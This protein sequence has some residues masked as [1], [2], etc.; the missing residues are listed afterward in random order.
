MLERRE[1]T[2][3]ERGWIDVWLLIQFLEAR[4]FDSNAP[5]AHAL[6]VNGNAEVTGCWTL[7]FCLDIATIAVAVDTHRAPP[8]L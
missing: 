3:L 4:T 5:T 1:I 8:G 6:R 2:R 7:E